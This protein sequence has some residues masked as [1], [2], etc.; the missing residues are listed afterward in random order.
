MENVMNIN[1]SELELMLANAIYALEISYTK[2]DI[3]EIVGIDED[4]YAYIMRGFIIVE[5]LKNGKK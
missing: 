1:K 2:E 4:K 5:G 3:M